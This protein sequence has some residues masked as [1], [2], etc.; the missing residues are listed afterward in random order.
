MALD[1]N[2]EYA[3]KIDGSMCRRTT[4]NRTWTRGRI[5]AAALLSL[6]LAAVAYV[7]VASELIINGRHPLPPSRVRASTQPDAVI[8]GAHLAVIGGCTGCHGES[9][10][11][12]RFDGAPMEIYAPNLGVLATTWADADFDRAIRRGL[13]PDGRTLW[14]MPSHSYQFMADQ[15]VATLIAYI[16]TLPQTG[17][18]MPG[19]EFDLATRLAILRNRVSSEMKLAADSEPS[20]DLGPSTASGRRIAAMTCVECHGSD[21]SGTYL[22]PQWA[23][24][25]LAVVAAYSRTDFSI[26]MRTGVALGNRELRSMSDIA[27]QRFVHLTDAEVSALYDYLVALGSQR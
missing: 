15:D 12:A 23:P 26:F 17:V 14:I 2:A 9:L 5:A 4:M 25:N 21:L 24:P 18:S 13:G 6:G 8:G 10:Q 22:S 1:G 27:R 16:R 3:K 19:P 11:G 7:Y 20:M